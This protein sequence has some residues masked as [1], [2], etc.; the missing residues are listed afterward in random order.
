MENE[1]EPS[2]WTQ[3]EQYDPMAAQD[4]NAL[5]DFGDLDID[6]IN[7]GDTVFEPAAGSR[8]DSN[9]Q[10][11][12]QQL[13]NEL[14]DSLNAQHLQQFTPPVSHRNDNATPG[15]HDTSQA[16][17]FYDFNMAAFTPATQAHHVSFSAPQEPVFHAHMGVP[18]TPNSIEMHGDAARYLQQMDPQ[19]RAFIEQRYQLR[20]EEVV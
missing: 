14:A 7:F 16:H 10:D 13:S 5:I 20:K 11:P 12:N 2:P 1:T 9:S 6:S 8:H 4:F 17:D 15:R 3:A 19:T 18:P